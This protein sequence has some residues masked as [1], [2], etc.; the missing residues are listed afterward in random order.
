M[1][2]EILYEALEVGKTYTA[3]GTLMVVTDEYEGT[4][5]A[6]PLLD[7][8]GNKV[9]GSH[10]FVPSTSEGSIFVDFEVDTQ[11]LQGARLV[12]FECLTCEG[13]IIA[14]HEDPA[15]ESQT[16][17]VE[18]DQEPEPPSLERSS[19]GKLP[20]TGDRAP[21]GLFTLMAAVAFGGA[22][23]FR[24]RLHLMRRR[25]AHLQL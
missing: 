10:T 8:S 6:A 3:F 9:T 11:D 17:W 19:G 20:Q 18:D 14:A 22:L 5:S 7:D 25:D 4:I 15:A 1:T 2:D 16:V 23:L 24:K 12:A 13:R 21:L